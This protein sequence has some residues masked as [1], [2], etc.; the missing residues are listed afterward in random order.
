MCNLYAMT[1]PRDAVRQ[2]FRVARDQT[3]NQGALPAVFPDQ[4]APVICTADDGGRV[5][6]TM[7]WGFPPPQSGPG[8]RPVTNIRNTA[9]TFWRGWLKPAYRC[10]VPATSF[11]E[12]D[13]TDAKRP[14]WFALAEDR[15]VFAFAGLWRPW[16]GTRKGETGAH[17]LFAFLTTT[18]NA[19]VRPVHAK[20]MPVILTAAACDQWLTAELPAALAL[21]R[22]LADGQLRVVAR[23]L[24]QDG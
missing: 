11:C 22:P 6:Q 4:L 7:R 19:E 18:A 5:M 8:A 20:A 10:L 12:Y 15:P 17:L 1:R 16:T 21:Q 2:I 14:T 23:G 24:R 9:S 13:D 3:A